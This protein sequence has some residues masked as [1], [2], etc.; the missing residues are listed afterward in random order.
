M[1]QFDE[2]LQTDQLNSVI[3]EMR[4]AQLKS[5]QQIA[6]LTREAEDREIRFSL[7]HEKVSTLEPSKHDDDDDN[8]SQAS[9]KSVTSSRGRY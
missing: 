1:S 8:R 6:R 3:E 4:A 9:S 5:D 7:L 2:A